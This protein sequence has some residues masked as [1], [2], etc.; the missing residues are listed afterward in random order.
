[1]AS[2]PRAIAALPA[3]DVRTA[4]QAL[5]QEAGDDLSALRQNI[6]RW[7]DDA[8]ER[9]S[10]WYKRHVTMILRII[11][12]VVAVLMNVDTFRIVTALRESSALRESAVASA[13]QVMADR[14]A[15]MTPRAKQDR[16]AKLE[17]TLQRL[18]LPIGLPTP[19][20]PSVV[21]VFS[22]EAKAAET[23][24]DR[25]NASGAKSTP[26]LKGFDLVWAIVSTMIGWLIT[27]AALSLGAPFWFDTLNKLLNLRSAGPRP[28]REDE[29]ALT[30]AGPA[31]ASETKMVVATD[32]R[33]AP[34]ATTVAP[35]GPQNE[36]ESTALSRDDVVDLQ[37]RLGIADHVIPGVLDTPTREAIQR[38]Q[39]NLGLE[40]TG[41][42]SQALAKHV[43]FG[44]DDVR[45]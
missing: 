37:H 32:A 28:P 19:W 11:A 13:Q 24:T 33:A 18:D 45:Q 15:L 6:E 38:A 27:A 5:A 22:G 35:T 41:R 34:T 21:D 3:G 17:A 42:L 12:I 39:T 9:V 30:A 31:V 10:G 26:F 1:M 16:D 14:D 29:K 36:F 43:L 2:V 20:W 4:L 44:G 23:V 25:A 40:P 8:M 7:F